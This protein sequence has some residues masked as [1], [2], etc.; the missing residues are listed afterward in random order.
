MAN[1]FQQHFK[2]YKNNELHITE[3][4]E[5]IEK[6]EFYIEVFDYI[7]KYKGICSDFRFFLYYI[8]KNNKNEIFEEIY[9]QIIKYDLITENSIKFFIE[10][11]KYT[12]KKDNL[13]TI[14]H[15]L[16][17]SSLTI[18]NEINFIKNKLHN[19]YNIENF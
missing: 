18:D 13:L 15:Y 16:D 8:L 7:S 2:S 14:L 17:L 10:Y 11:S 3:F 1:L 12:N 4:L 9:N 19:I 5:K 6:K